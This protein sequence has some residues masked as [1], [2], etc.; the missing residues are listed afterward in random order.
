MIERCLGHRAEARVWFGRALALNPH[1]SLLWAAAA[2]RLPRDETTPRSSS[3]HVA[4]LALAD[5]PQRHPLGNFTINRFSRVEVSGHRLYVRYV[6]DMAEIPTFQA[7]QGGI[8][9]DRVRTADRRG[10]AS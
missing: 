6:L 9:R 3:G 4:R 10:D 7:R 2:R 1:F 5:V 8:D